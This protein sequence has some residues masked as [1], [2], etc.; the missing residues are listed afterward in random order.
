MISRAVATATVRSELLW[1]KSKFDLCVHD[2]NVYILFD[3]LHVKCIKR[4]LTIHFIPTC[5]GLLILVMFLWAVCEYHI[6]LYIA[7]WVS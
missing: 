2:V 1:F 6:F 4:I 5:L 3:D 7:C